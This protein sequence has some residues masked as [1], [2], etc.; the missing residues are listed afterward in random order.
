M[1]HPHSSGDNS[2]AELSASVAP[3]ELRRELEVLCSRYKRM[4]L[5]RSWRWTMPMRRAE[6]LLHRM[7]RWGSSKSAQLTEPAGQPPRNEQRE[8]D[9][10]AVI[11]PCH[12]YGRYLNKAVE[13][14]LNQ[15]LRPQEI[16]IVDDASDDDTRAIADAFMPYGISVIHGVWRDVSLARNTGAALTRARYLLF[17]DADDHLPPEYIETC[18]NVMQSDPT[19]GIVYPDMTFFGIVNQQDRIMEFDQD[20]FERISFVT[21]CALLNRQAF[22]MVGG[23]RSGIEHEDWDL[24]RRI[25][26]L[27]FRAKRA[28]TQ[29]FYRS[30]LDS[31]FRRCMN[32][33][34]NNY[35]II[36]NLDRQPLTLFTWFSGD[37]H[38]SDGYF[39]ALRNLACDPSF[40]HLH[41]Y[42]SSLDPAF[43]ARL[44]HALR[45]LP[46]AQKTITRAPALPLFDEVSTA[47][48]KGVLQDMKSAY[49]E[50][51]AALQAY[52]TFLSTCTT[53]FAVTL[54]EDLAPAPDS[55]HLLL[56]TMRNDT[57][58]VISPVPCPFRGHALVWHRRTDGSLKY[59]E[60]KG[61][62]VEEVNGGGFGFALFRM[63]AFRNLPL[64][65][66]IHHGSRGELR[67]HFQE[68]AFDRL[69]SSGRILCNWD[70]S[71]NRFTVNTTTE[72]FLVPSNGLTTSV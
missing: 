8:T 24:F 17:L 66:N 23:Y 33:P 36:A 47:L 64:I 44:E 29:V 6:K 37:A 35:R 70:I 58:A 28:D 72:T 5:S 34:R 25:L 4:A 2:P 59:A 52:N 21:S 65:T 43:N 30:H 39:H 19:L 60:R 53:E 63:R 26:R 48:I 61:S 42:S 55:L 9:L 67:G 51:I 7:M 31:R 56:D 41:W 1:L 20:V 57:E 18:L 62:G 69:S 38:A 68:L 22:D 3:G 14:V 71:I 49:Q 16:V 45:E 13:S 40:V 11:I 50:E 12:N 46:F 54:E 27:S 15:T 32:N 10:V